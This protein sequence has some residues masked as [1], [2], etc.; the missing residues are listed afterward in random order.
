MARANATD[1]AASIGL[2]PPKEIKTSGRASAAARVAAA[3]AAAGACWAIAANWPTSATAEQ[4][5]ELAAQR[6]IARDAAR[7]DDK[8]ALH[9]ALGELLLEVLG[10]RA[11]APVDCARIGVAERARIAAIHGIRIRTALA[12]CTLN[13]ETAAH[14]VP[15]RR[16][17]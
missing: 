17:G 1:L 2:P 6:W 8:R 10:E 13:H 12:G 16:K 15:P 5:L 3:T 11:G 4:V 9:V 14:N 7:A